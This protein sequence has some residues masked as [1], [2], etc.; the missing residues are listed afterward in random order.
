MKY[1]N[2]KYSKSHIV[3]S[4]R[5]YGSPKVPKRNTERLFNVTPRLTTDPEPLADEDYQLK[6]YHIKEVYVVWYKYYLITIV[7]SIC[8]ESIFCAR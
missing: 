5:A 1:Y 4:Y 3:Y 6:K 2:V 7:D 8:I